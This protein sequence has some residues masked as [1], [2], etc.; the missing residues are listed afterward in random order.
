VLAGDRGRPGRAGPAP[1]HADAGGSR[2]DAV[3]RGRL[4][5]ELDRRRAGIRDLEQAT[6]AGTGL[7]RLIAVRHG[8]H[9]VAVLVTAERRRLGDEAERLGSDAGGVGHGQLGRRG[10]Y[11]ADFG[12]QGTGHVVIL[13]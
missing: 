13:S 5:L 12:G 2:G 7:V 4:T 10:L 8:E 11:D 1:R 6:P 9:E 3:G